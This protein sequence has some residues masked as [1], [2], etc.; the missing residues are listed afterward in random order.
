[1]PESRP[2]RGAA[3]L[4]W[5]EEEASSPKFQEPQRREQSAKAG[6]SHDTSMVWPVVS[7]QSSWE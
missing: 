1:M 5:V 7:L 6:L 4:L 2:G 3:P